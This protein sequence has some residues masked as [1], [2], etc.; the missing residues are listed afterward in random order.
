MRAMRIYEARLLTCYQAGDEDAVAKALDRLDEES[1]DAEAGAHLE[2]ETAN[3][4]HGLHT[5]AEQ[6]QEAN[7]G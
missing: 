6:W 5:I 3:E 4:I 7:R 1:E 2:A